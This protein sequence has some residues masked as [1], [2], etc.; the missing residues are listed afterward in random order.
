M[1]RNPA[2]RLR[3]TL[4]DQARTELRA[5]LGESATTLIPQ[6]EKSVQSYL[7]MRKEEA[8]ADVRKAEEQEVDTIVA[9]LEALVRTID[10]A[11]PGAWGALLE[12]DLVILT[13]N[14]DLD[15]VG[16]KVTRLALA[17]ASAMAK[18]CVRLI[19]IGREKRGP[20]RPTDVV[21]SMFVSDV[22]Q[23]LTSSGI[24][25]STSRGGLL[26]KVL[27]TLLYEADGRS[28]EDLF[29]IIQKAT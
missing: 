27:T 23:L 16:T 8:P 3:F 10:G 18:S 4:S 24:K 25:V 29:R 15:S 28:P 5:F 26:T 19:E 21:R 17:N 20:G 7:R 6:L 22:K 14:P 12:Y 13:H 11:S 2:S 1:P 9:A